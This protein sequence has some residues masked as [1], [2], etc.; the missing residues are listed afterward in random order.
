MK[1]KLFAIAA[2]F[3]VVLFAGI[4]FGGGVKAEAGGVCL[5]W[6][7]YFGGGWSSAPG[8]PIIIEDTVIV[9][10]GAEVY[11]LSLE[12]GS[13][14]DS[15][16]TGYSL[17]YAIVKPCSFV[18]NGKYKILM[19]L[20][21]GK[22]ACV[23]Y[24]TLEEDWTYVDELRGQCNSPIIYGD[25]SLYTGF[26]NGETKDANFVSINAETGEKQWSYTHTGGFYWAGAVVLDGKVIV[27][28]DDGASGYT[29]NGVLL[30]LSAE[31]GT[32]L[33]S[34]NVYGDQRSQITYVGE[35]EE[36]IVT[37]K[38]GWLYAVG[39]DETGEFVQRGSV[40][41]YA[42]QSTSQPMVHN[43][44]IYVCSGGG[45]NVGGVVEVI[46]YDTL[47]SIYCVESDYYPQCGVAL[48]PKGEEVDVYYNYNGYPGGIRKFTDGASVTSNTGVDFFV[49][50][51]AYQQYCIGFL[52]VSGNKLVYKNDS[53]TVFCLNIGGVQIQSDVYS[54][55]FDTAISDEGLTGDADIFFVSLS[56]DAADYGIIVRDGVKEF[57]Y[58]GKRKS[59]DNR[60]AIAIFGLPVGKYTVTP[61]ADGVSG[62]SL[63]YEVV[64]EVAV[65]KTAALAEIDSYE[66]EAGLTAFADYAPASDAFAVIVGNLK[67]DVN[68]AETT[69]EVEVAL[70]DAKATMDKLVVTASFSF[71]DEGEFVLTK[72]GDPVADTEID[73]PYFDLADYGYEDY[74]RYEADSFENGGAYISN[75]LVL[76]PT[77]MHA[78]IYLHVLYSE[79]GTDDLTISGSA[80]GT[81]MSKF[82]GMDENLNYYVDY[83]YPLMA[84]GWGAT[85][86]YILLEDGMVVSLAHWSDYGFWTEGV[87]F[88]F[89]ENDI[90]NAN[91]GE[92]VNFALMYNASDMMNPSPVLTE[93]NYEWTIGYV[94]ADGDS[95][96]PGDAAEMDYVTDYDGDGICDYTFENA[97]TYYVVFKDSG[98]SA[99]SP[100]YFFAP[101]IV[102]VIV[103]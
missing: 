17:G 95:I 99:G 44:R 74:Y 101:Y 78:F 6:Q 33:S 9:F 37:T 8:N 53:T 77:V 68:A 90:I 38:N 50:E 35:H 62:A 64:D 29:G 93:V 3:A 39:L 46:D 18:L 65:A 71:S 19:G 89:L 40:D 92:Q 79:N 91:A 41:L 11:K 31:D 22:V 103:G 20:S 72:D 30:C 36:F 87:K 57:T 28:G 55:T 60:F 15:K 43:G 76:Q 54:G 7:H 83:A 69:A 61:Y 23:D 66:A 47:E 32:L 48:V 67:A 70:A 5:E 63:E 21:G 102:K 1:K 84:E 86:D 26:W 14:I 24:E 96:L 56:E 85:S 10:K 97:G 13:V 25:G 27:G 88:A 82:W 98:L 2:M 100:E 4:S 49:P 80:T 81:Y 94:Y 58:T 16:T 51:E 42:N 34:M 52:E 45:I 12:D 75:N 73:V 59:E